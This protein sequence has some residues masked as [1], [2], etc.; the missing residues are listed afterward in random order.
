MN[1]KT[2]LISKYEVVPDSYASD[3]VNKNTELISKNIVVPD[4]N[5]SNQS[6]L[7]P[8]L[9]QVKIDLSRPAESGSDE[10]DCDGRVF[11]R[12][13]T[14]KNIYLSCVE[15]SLFSNSGKR[16]KTDRVY[17]IRHPCSFC[18]DLKTNFSHHIFSKKH[19]KE[20]VIEIKNAKNNKERKSSI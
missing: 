18:K 3:I 6:E 5:D 15:K 13:V 20:E 9:K 8:L 7:F 11:A 4:S 17:N 10:E 19:E 1:K 12:D 14:H 2:E 16:T